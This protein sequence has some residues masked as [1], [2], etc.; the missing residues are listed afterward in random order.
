MAPRPPTIPSSWARPPCVK[1]LAFVRRKFREHPAKAVQKAEVKY[2]KATGKYHFH[3]AAPSTR[4][5]SAASFP[6]YGRSRRMKSNTPKKAREA[7]KQGAKA[8]EKTVVTTEKA[9]GKSRGLLSK[10]IQSLLVIALFALLLVI[11]VQS[12]TSALTTI[13]NGTVGSISATTYPSAD[14]DLLGPRS[15]TAAWRRSAA[16]LDG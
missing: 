13:G 5:W 11:V 3:A 7:A 2:A 4:K 15:P 16:Y 12:C 14:A 1:A 10:G 9:G 8:A 6:A